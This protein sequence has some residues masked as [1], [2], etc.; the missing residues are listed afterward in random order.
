[1]NILIED[2][3]KIIKYSEKME[4]QLNEALEKLDITNEKLDDANEELEDINEKL[5]NTD[6]H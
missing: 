2:N 1:M 3:K 4:M 5:D 6:K